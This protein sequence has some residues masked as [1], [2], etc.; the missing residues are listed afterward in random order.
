MNQRNKNRRNNMRHT[1]T[2]PTGTVQTMTNEAVLKWDAEY[3][4][5]FAPATKRHKQFGVTYA[6]T[7]YV[8]RRDLIAEMNAK[9]LKQLARLLNTTIVDKE[10]RIKVSQKVDNLRANI[11]GVLV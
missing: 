7:T 11:I 9:Q 8:A 10:A 6:H 3:A 1:V 2:H 4:P 5:A